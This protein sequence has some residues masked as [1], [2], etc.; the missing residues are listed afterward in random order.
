MKDELKAACARLHAELVRDRRLV[1]Y[2]WRAGVA[3]ASP[4]PATEDAS[5]G[6]RPFVSIEDQ[7]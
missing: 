5:W 4:Y 3:L 1:P 7:P 2:L 6:G